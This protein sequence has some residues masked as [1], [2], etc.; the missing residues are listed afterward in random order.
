E[1]SLNLADD[2]SLLAMM[3][4][5]GFMAIFVGIES[6]DEQTLIDTQKRQNTRRSI[7]ESVQ[8]IYRYGIA[9]NAGY[10]LG[11]DS[12]GEGVAQG[13]IDC[14]RDTAVP[15]NMAGLLFA[16][17]TTQLSRRLQKEGRLHEGYELA[18]EGVGDQCTA[19]LNFDTRRPRV[20]ILRDYL[21]VI[22]T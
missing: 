21:S 12:E 22:E 11:C 4:D 17:P 20:D 16:L 14:V 6:P 10:I 18:P 8:T 9:V 3:Q 15:V 19:G 13:I 1:A 5:V 7:A 2:K